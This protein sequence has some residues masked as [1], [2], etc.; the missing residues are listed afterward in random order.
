MADRVVDAL[1]QR[2]RWDLRLDANQQCAGDEIELETEARCL[3]V[4]AQSVLQ[5]LVAIQ[6]GDPDAVPAW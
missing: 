1:Q 2:L 5:P 3:E 6:T 4:A